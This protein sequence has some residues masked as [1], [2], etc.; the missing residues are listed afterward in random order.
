[1]DP[2]AIRIVS[3]E[4]TGLWALMS[5]DDGRAERVDRATRQAQPAALGAASEPAL[6]EPGKSG[7]RPLPFRVKPVDAHLR[8]RLAG[9]EHH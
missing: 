7:A 1:V 9:L 2:E 4:A 8:V 6:I 5:G 3:I